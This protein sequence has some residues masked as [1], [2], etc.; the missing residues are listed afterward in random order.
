MNLIELE[1]ESQSLSVSHT[2]RIKSIN[3]LKMRLIGEWL[4]LVQSFLFFFF[5][6]LDFTM[7]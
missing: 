5:L 7:L 6:L 1:I 3:L 4:N 2:L